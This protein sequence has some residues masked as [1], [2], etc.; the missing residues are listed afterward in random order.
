MTLASF[1]FSLLAYVADNPKHS[2]SVTF[3]QPILNTPIHLHKVSEE[4]HCPHP[5]HINVY[6]FQHLAHHLPVK[7]VPQISVFFGTNQKW[8]NHAPC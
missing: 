2:V 8:H 5:K 7:N 6:A 1:S 4:Q 3:V